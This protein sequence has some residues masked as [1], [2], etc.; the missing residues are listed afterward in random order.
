MIPLS[1]NC[2]TA[3][4]LLL[5]ARVSFAADDS[6]IGDVDDLDMTQ[7]QH[8]ALGKKTPPKSLPTIGHAAPEVSPGTVAPGVLD[9]TSTAGACHTSCHWFLASL[10]PRKVSARGSQSTK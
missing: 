6:D 10:W 5:A 8:S 9:L 4:I 7:E 1:G 3:L 2:L